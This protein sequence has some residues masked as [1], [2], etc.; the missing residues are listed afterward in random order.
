[1]ATGTVTAALHEQGN[2][3]GVEAGCKRNYSGI[4]C[5]AYILR[6]ILNPYDKSQCIPVFFLVFTMFFSQVSS[7]LSTFFPGSFQVS[8]PK[9]PWQVEVSPNVVTYNSLLAARSNASWRWALA[10]LSEMEEVKLQPETWI[11]RKTL[12]PWWIGI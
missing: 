3:A 8:A 6:F 1:V 7:F 9:F 4:V 10:L 12:R 2:L 11:K 5:C